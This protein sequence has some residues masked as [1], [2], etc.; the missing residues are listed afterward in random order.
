[1]IGPLG[2]KRAGID[3]QQQ[4]PHHAV[5]VDCPLFNRGV[6]DAQHGQVGAVHGAAEVERV[7]A[8]GEAG[9]QAGAAGL[10]ISH[11]VAGFENELLLRQA[12]QPR[13]LARGKEEV[14]VQ[15][16]PPDNIMALGIDADIGGHKARIFETQ[17]G[18]AEL[19]P[20]HAG[21]VDFQTGYE[22]RA[23]PDKLKCE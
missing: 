13:Q 2:L 4:T 3:H 7:R 8:P 17:H 5:V 9:F 12:D 21:S 22:F 23:T 6:L 16:R 15:R 14:L 1:M 18:G 20:L 10:V 19:R 11:I